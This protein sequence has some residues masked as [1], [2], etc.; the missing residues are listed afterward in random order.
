MRRGPEGRTDIPKFNNA[1]D[2]NRSDLHY[3]DHPGRSMISVRVVTIAKTTSV[4][5]KLL[6]C[7]LGIQIIQ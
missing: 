3:D 6:K 2:E 7:V 5:G 1:A 4:G